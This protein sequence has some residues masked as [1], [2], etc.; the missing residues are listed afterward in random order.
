M[1]HLFP[2]SRFFVWPQPNTRRAFD[3]HSTISLPKWNEQTH[4]HT[5]D[6]TKLIIIEFLERWHE[7]WK[8][9][10]K[11][12]NSLFPGTSMA[13]FTHTVIDNEISRCIR[14]R[15]FSRGESAI[16]LNSGRS[17]QQYKRERWKW[18]DSIYADWILNRRR[19]RKRNLWST[20]WIW[21]SKIFRRKCV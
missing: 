10:A 19:T 7:L 2:N 20:F 5:S 6:T 17:F 11:S 1:V 21:F 3:I 16:Q 14:M 9:Q 4:T 18:S 12:L 8:N 13:F 15:W